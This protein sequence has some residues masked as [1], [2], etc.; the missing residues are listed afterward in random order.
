ML[1]TAFQSIL[2]CGLCIPTESHADSARS[3]DSDLFDAGDKE[4]QCQGLDTVLITA[5]SYFIDR[6]QRLVSN[7]LIL[8]KIKF[9]NIHKIGLLY[10]A[11]NN[12]QIE[13]CSFFDS[14]DVSK[15]A[16]TPNPCEMHV[17]VAK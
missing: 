4:G 6:F 2:L 10:N 8:N 5:G 9:R 14:V 16:T 13:D 17:C 3:L 7:L 12:G 1:A 15:F 11:I